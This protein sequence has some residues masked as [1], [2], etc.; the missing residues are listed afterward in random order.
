MRREE[1]KGKKQRDERKRKG[2]EKKRSRGRL[3][4]D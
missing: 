4:G 1:K 2:I 3:K